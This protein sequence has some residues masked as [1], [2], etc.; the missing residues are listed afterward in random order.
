MNDAG[1][2]GFTAFFKDGSSGVFVATPRLSRQPDLHIGN[3][4]EGR[5]SGNNIYNAHGLSQTREQRA[6]ADVSATYI[7]RLQNDS[8][9]PANFKITGTAG[10][11]QFTVRYFN[12]ANGNDI[13]SQVTSADG[14]RPETMPVAGARRIRL[15]VE[16]T[17][18]A[19]AGTKFEVLVRARSV[20]EFAKRDV[21]RA[22]TT[23]GAF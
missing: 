22:V 23:A 4:G 9:D 15:V 16:P 19:T 20:F 5:F 11:S 18:A 3:Q 12:V 21:V 6:T 8:T 2:L 17:V 13:T 10:S 1:Q 14:W 7:I